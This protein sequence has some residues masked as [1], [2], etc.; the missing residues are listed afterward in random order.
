MALLSN[1]DSSRCRAVAFVVFHALASSDARSH[2]L[3]NMWLSFM[4]EGTAGV[5][6]RRNAT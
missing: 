5:L 6:A 4:Q 3:R 1:F 2:V